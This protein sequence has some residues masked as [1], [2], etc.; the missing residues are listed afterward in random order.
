MTKLS[1]KFDKSIK[2]E[3]SS[4]FKILKRENKLF[5]L[6]SKLI[7]RSK[8]YH[9]FLIHFILVILAITFSFNFNEIPI[10]K[11]LNF[12]EID[13]NYAN[14]ILHEFILYIG[15]FISV[16]LIVTT[17]LFNFLKEQLDSNIK[18]IVRYVNY[19]IVAYYGFGL[20]I[21]LITQ[22]LFSL[23]LS[24]ERLKNLLILDF[25]LLIIFLFLL[26][27]LY[28]RIFEII[29]PTKLKE[30]NLNDTRRI[31]ALN[32]F[33]VLYEV[34]SK[35]IIQ[36]SFVENGFQEIDNLNHFIV[37]E[38][39]N[40]L[41][42]LYCEDKSK[43]KYLNDIN[44]KKLFKRTSNFETK[45]FVPLN[46]GQ[47]FPPDSDYLLLALEKNNKKTK[48]NRVFNYLLEKFKNYEFLKTA[49]TKKYNNYL[50]KGYKFSKKTI[51]KT[52]AKDELEEKLE[53]IT[54]DLTDSI[55]KR[56][57]K[58]IKKTL[59]DLDI[60]IELYTENFE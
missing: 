6:K 44:F 55:Y 58:G 41:Y 48:Y 10:L 7:L 2:E 27:F 45:Q 37:D 29:K 9:Y 52:Y 31:C 15:T 13:D 23:T 17:F 39:R 46:L 8:W 60:I 57:H 40:D 38:Q 47:Y 11:Y 18:L 54:E 33:Y 59:N 42:Y 43:D 28:V 53:F 3:H 50:L 35:R 4:L 49:L 16:T 56:N 1:A 36:E 51:E 14:K 24:F 20:I 26:V 34:K 19:E 5:L 25:Y 12:I 22:K 32:I 21:S 30:V